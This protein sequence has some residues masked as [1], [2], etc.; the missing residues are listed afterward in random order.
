MRFLLRLWGVFLPCQMKEV[1]LGRHVYFVKG[2]YAGGAPGGIDIINDGA[3]LFL[4]LQISFL[5]C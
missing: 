4:S 5:Q 3:N 2:T 1:T